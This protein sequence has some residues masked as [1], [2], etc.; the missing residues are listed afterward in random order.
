MK[1]TALFLAMAS[2][3]AFVNAETVEIPVPTFYGKFNV[4]QE[5]IQ[6][7]E[8]GNFSELN[9]NASRLG[10]KGDFAINDEITAF[11]QAEFQMDTDGDAGETFS[12]RNTFI[13]AKGSFGKVQA[14]IFD[15]ALKASQKKVDQFND[16]RADIKNY[17]TGSENRP[18]DIVRYQSPNLSGLVLTLDHINGEEED[19][20]NAQSFSAAF[21]QD[22]LYVALAYDNGLEGTGVETTR[23]VGQLNLDGG[24]QLGALWETEDDNGESNDGM[25]VS[26]AVKAASKVKLKAQYASSDIRAEGATQITLGADYKLANNAKVFAY[27]SDVDTDEN[28]GG[29]VFAVGAEYKF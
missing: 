12:E 21:T 4:S 24:I 22:V 28:G 17:V 13:G 14:G 3:T 29:Q 20:P 18:S 27:A 9:S 10:L 1:K 26:A 23:L 8:A 15:S 2:A 5:F 25:M 11:Y 19:T 7:D 16:L 6:Q